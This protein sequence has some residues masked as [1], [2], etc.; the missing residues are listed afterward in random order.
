MRPPGPP[1]AATWLLRHFGRG[2]EPLAG[3]PLDEFRDGRTAHWYWRQVMT[4]I[5][6]DV[7]KRIWA[8]RA[9]GLPEL[10]GLAFRV[11]VASFF[12]WPVG[13]GRRRFPRISSCPARP[14]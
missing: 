6:T 7:P 1:R 3:D 2:N 13:P 10:A 12:T 5:L 8:N 4:A 14:A 11:G 9:L